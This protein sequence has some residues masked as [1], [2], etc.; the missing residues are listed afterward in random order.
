MIKVYGTSR[1][2]N[3]DAVKRHLTKLNVP[4]EYYDVLADDNAMKEF[5]AYK[6]S[7]VPLV[8]N[9]FG[10]FTTGLN[11]HTLQHLIEEEI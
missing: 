9:C 11:T 1:C 4:F 5:E 8:V 6:I 10:N 3:C 2:P 7:S